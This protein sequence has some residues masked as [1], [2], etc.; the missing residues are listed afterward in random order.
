MPIYTYIV[1]DRAGKTVTG[2]TEAPNIASASDLLRERG[3][4]IITLTE[5]EV[6][7]IQ[8][9]LRRVQG[10]GLGEKAVL[11]R[12]LSTM[13]SAGVPLSDA[14]EILHSQA[15]SERMKEVLGELV[16]GVQGGTS[17][18]KSMAKY[19]DVFGRVLVALVEAGEASGKLDLIL[20]Q[21]ADNLEKEKD[22][23]SKTK[24]ALV[25][26][27]IILLAMA[28]VFI[29]ITTFVVPRLAALYADIGVEL[30]LPTKILI[31]ISSLLTGGWWVFLALFS[32]AGYAIFRYLQTPK[33]KYHIASLTFGFPVFGKL[34]KEAELT[35]FSRTLGLLLS[36]GIPITQALEIV[37]G[38]MDN[39]LYRDAVLEAEKQVQRGI[40]LSVPIK[41]D[42]N[43]PP[44]LAQMIAVGEETGK[45]DEVLVKVSTFFESQAGETVSNLSTAIE[46]LIMIVLGV[47]VGLLVLSIITPIYNLTTKF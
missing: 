6:S 38:A 12:Q 23:Q 39:I 45:L 2:T 8:A 43:F 32:A 33:G 3:F 26:P 40:P 36:A 46:P 20:A 31:G 4:I 18:S 14:L 34:N 44:I 1:K 13:V 29:I 47:M 28:V 5:R 22:F 41:A 42:P 35:R 25:Y 16:S 19:P 7:W 10:I 30:P 37:A 15:E 17:L 9:L 21:L 11:V 24:G 27:A